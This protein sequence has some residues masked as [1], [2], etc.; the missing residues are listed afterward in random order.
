MLV[1]VIWP[2][3]HY[4][5]AIKNNEMLQQKTIFPIQNVILFHVT[6]VWRL[7]GA[8]SQLQLRFEKKIACITYVQIV[9][10]NRYKNCIITKKIVVSF[11]WKI[12]CLNAS[13]LFLPNQGFWENTELGQ[14]VLYGTTWNVLQNN[15]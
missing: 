14:H 15:K 10:N 4:H 3:L 13:I 7:C 8:S 12:D 1:F 11:Y 6:C 2:K 9:R 5:N